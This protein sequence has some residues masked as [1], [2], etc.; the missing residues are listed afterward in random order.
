MP[1]RPFLARPGTLPFLSSL[2]SL[3]TIAHGAGHMP[4]GIGIKMP[5]GIRPRH[6]SAEKNQ[7]IGPK[8]WLN[9][10]EFCARLFAR[11]FAIWRAEKF[12]PAARH[13][14]GH[15]PHFFGF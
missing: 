7:R 15:R 6:S 8:N 1:F 14:K 3:I 4:S 11:L 5:A 10:C 12:R 2:S 13:K 9:I